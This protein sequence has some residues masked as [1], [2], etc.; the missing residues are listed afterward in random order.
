MKFTPREFFQLQAF[1]QKIVILISSLFYN[2]N[3]A[4]GEELKKLLIMYASHSAPP[5]V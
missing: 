1:P 3:L 5:K 4:F 2:L